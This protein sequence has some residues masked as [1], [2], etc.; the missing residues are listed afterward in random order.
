MIFPKKDRPPPQDR[1]EDLVLSPWYH[2]VC[3]V[4]QPHH[5]VCVNAAYA[6]FHRRLK[7]GSTNRSKAKT[8]QQAVF[9][10]LELPLIVSPIIA[11]HHIINWFNHII[12]NHV[13]Q[14]LFCKKQFNRKQS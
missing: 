1:D 6:R 12:Q 3:A 7:G 4:L 5:F 11:N 2:P 9:S 8:F 10:L 13:L 14:V